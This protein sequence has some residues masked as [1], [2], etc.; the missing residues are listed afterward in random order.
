MSENYFHRVW[1]LT[2]HRRLK[3]VI[4]IMECHP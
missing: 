4:V 1:T 2:A 3:N